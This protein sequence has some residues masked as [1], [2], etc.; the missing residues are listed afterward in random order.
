GGTAPTAPRDPLV[1]PLLGNLRLPLL[2]VAS[3][4]RPPAQPLIVELCHLL[5]ALHEPRKLLEL[6]PLIVGGS[7]WHLDIDGFLDS[8]H[9][10]L[11]CDPSSLGGNGQKCLRR[12]TRAAPP[13]GRTSRGGSGGAPRSITDS[14]SEISLATSC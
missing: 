1:R 13:S 10:T 5:Y 7:H 3:Y 14:R 11:L 4:V 2:L 6:R 9:L 12:R 8:G